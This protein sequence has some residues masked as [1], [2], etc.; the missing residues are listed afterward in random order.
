MSVVSWMIVGLVTTSLLLGGGESAWLRVALG[1][2]A[3]VL[4]GVALLA[5]SLR[6]I[7]GTASGVLLAWVALAL[8]QS[9]SALGS[10]DG[11]LSVVALL[12][13]LCVFAVCHAAVPRRE[14]EWLLVALGIGGALVAGVALWSVAP[15]ASASFPLATPDHLAGWLVLPTLLGVAALCLCAPEGRGAH[16]TI[17]WFCAVTLCG[18]AIAA[19]RS[20]VALVAIGV[21]ASTL[22]ALHRLPSRRGFTAGVVLCGM[23]LVSVAPA[24]H[25]PGSAAFS[26]A[27]F[28]PGSAP[29]SY[30][31][32]NRVAALLLSAAIVLRRIR[33]LRRGRGSLAAWGGAAAVFCLAPLGLFDATLEVPATLLTAATL[34]GLAWPAPVGAAPRDIRRTRALLLVLAGGIAM[35]LFAGGVSTAA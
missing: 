21:A 28:A 30:E 13:S 23:L 29:G 9:R 33:P 17:G 15:G 35:A 14:R 16:W 6:P 12:A 8:A 34:A 19:S 5:R 24:L 26:E 27:G 22:V 20:V 18:A 7:S 31:P 10:A 1:A 2:G 11:A 25:A 3:A 32:F 4:A